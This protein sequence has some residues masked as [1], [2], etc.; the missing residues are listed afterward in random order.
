MGWYLRRSVKFGPLRLN[1]SKSGVGWSVG[2]KGAQI[3]HGPRGRYVHVGRGGL[4]YRQTISS[5][6]AQAASRQQPVTSA[7]DPGAVIVVMVALVAAGFAL[8]AGSAVGALL[9]FGL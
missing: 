1:L 8:A 5:N 9:L 4:Y 6:T 3:G 7:P 2:V